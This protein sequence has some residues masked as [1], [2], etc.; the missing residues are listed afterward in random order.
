ML[1]SVGSYPD[2]ML[3]VWGWKKEKIMLRSKV[4]RSIRFTFVAFAKTRGK[5]EVYLRGVLGNSP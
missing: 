4:S 3:T 2:Y 5:P 1:A